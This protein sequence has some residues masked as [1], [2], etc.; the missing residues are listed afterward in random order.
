MDCSR[1]TQSTPLTQSHATYL[2]GLCIALESRAAQ[3]A[4]R[5]TDALSLDFERRATAIY[6]GFES[7]AAE[8]QAQL[9][10]LR[11]SKADSTALAACAEQVHLGLLQARKIALLVTESSC[12]TPNLPTCLVTYTNALPTQ[13]TQMSE[14]FEEASAQLS[15]AQAAA[16]ASQQQQ[17]S[18]LSAQI[19]SL[20]AARA[21]DTAGAAAAITKLQ[22][23][24]EGCREGVAAGAAQAEAAGRRLN[25]QVRGGGRPSRS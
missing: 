6:E 20:D 25:E 1:L 9:D 23:G 8:L 18:S 12:Q 14:A 22:R 16:A 19:T 15:D 17:L 10:A 21:S 13:C 2:P 11:L 3:S 4:S 7:K 24:L 5:A